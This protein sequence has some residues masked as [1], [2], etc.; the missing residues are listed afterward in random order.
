MK[1]LLDTNICI[2]FLHRNDSAV[3]ELLKQIPTAEISLCS[4]V[5][6]ELIYGARKSQFVEKNLETLKSFFSIFE[7]FIFDDKAA[8]HYG[9]IH[10]TLSSA[11][12]I[13]GLNDILIASIALANDL[14]VVT[15]NTKEFVRVPGLRIEKW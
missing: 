1:Y 5:K 11:G 12:Q 13:I 7:S 6:A 4:V 2:A 10:A 14:V 3:K 15:R 9:L 8:E